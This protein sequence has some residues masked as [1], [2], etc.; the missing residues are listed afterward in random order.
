MSTLTAPR[1]SA[2]SRAKDNAK[3][4]QERKSPRLKKGQFN[5]DEFR[6][7][8]GKLHEICNS[9]SRVAPTL[10]VKSINALGPI[11]IAIMMRVGPRLDAGRRNQII[12]LLYKSADNSNLAQY[13]ILHE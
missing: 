7:A 8:A 12:E 4:A 9:A 3:K 11:G 1:M 10:L 5:E 6:I 13:N 2:A